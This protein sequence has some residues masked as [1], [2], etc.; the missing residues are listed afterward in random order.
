MFFE[1]KAFSATDTYDAAQV[2]L[3]SGLGIAPLSMQY[4][5]ARGFYALHETKM[6]LWIGLASGVLNAVLSL[7]VY[8]PFGVIGLSAV[9]SFSALFNAAGLTIFLR[10]RIGL[11][12]GRRMLDMLVRMA[13][14][15]AVLGLVCYYGSWAADR[16]LGAEGAASKLLSCLGPMAVGMAVFFGLCLVFRVEAMQT[17][18]NLAASRFR[19]ARPTPA[20]VSLTDPDDP[21]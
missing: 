18:L 3:W 21:A 11:M 15:S 1:G 7:L 17:A 19:R 2:L 12:E 6:P 8:Q 5:V 20:E 9:G 4:I 10:R 14:P 16:W 13:I